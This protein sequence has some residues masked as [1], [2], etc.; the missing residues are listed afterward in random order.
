M[1]KKYSKNQR[2]KEIFGILKKY[3]PTKTNLTPQMVR[4]ILEELGPTYIK[5]GQ[6]MS[7]RSDLLPNDYLKELEKL[8]TKVPQM[9]AEDFNYIIREAYQKDISLVF[10][11]FHDESLGSAS[12]AQVHLAKIKDTDDVVVLKVQRKDIFDTMEQD[13]MIMHRIARSLKFVDKKSIFDFD[14]ILDELWKTAIEEMDFC[15]EAENISEFHE[16]HKNNPYCYSPKVYEELSSKK[17]LVMEYIDGFFIDELDKY[18]E[19]N[20]DRKMIAKRL[21]E[22]FIRQVIENGFFHA[23]PHPGNLKIRDGKIVWLD[24]GMV[25]HLN[26]QDKNL[27]SDLIIGISH[28]DI[29]KIKDACL[30]LATV[31]GEVNHSKLYDD[32]DQFLRKYS[33]LDLGSIGLGNIIQ[34]LLDLLG[35]HNFQVPAKISMLARGIITLEGVLLKLDPTTSTLD[36][37][38]NYFKEKDNILETGFSKLQKAIGN[39]N[40]SMEKAID[41]PSYITDI[42]KMTAKGQL[43]MRS[44]LQISETTK[45]FLDKIVTKI[46][47]ALLAVAVIIGSSLIA[48]VEIQPIVFDLPLFTTIG[49]II[50]V[51]LSMSIFIRK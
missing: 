27:I 40:Y 17:I 9:S 31:N 8:R 6:V 10:D 50:A 20:L 1:A 5:L 12:I 46:I 21:A 51:F 29:G 43:K 15:K 42:V 28:H 19:N 35:T 37:L 16:F 18:E 25:G 23:D 26:S 22:D 38:I 14:K 36:L 48:L 41:L 34:D 32:L 2:L 39:L 45:T 33:S 11:D 44:E 47:T 30:V 49:Y 24:L 13:I 4:M 3:K 7:M